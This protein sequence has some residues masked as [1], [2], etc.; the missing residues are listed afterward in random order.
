L[1]SAIAATDSGGPFSFREKVSPF[2]TLWPGSCPA[3]FV[4]AAVHSDR[5]IGEHGLDAS[6]QTQHRAAI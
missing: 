3:D 1:I 4:V 6:R 5:L 2:S